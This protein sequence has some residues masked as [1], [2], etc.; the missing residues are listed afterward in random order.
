MGLPQKCQPS[1]QA[2]A[3]ESAS[4]RILSTTAERKLVTSVIQRKPTARS[5]IPSAE[6]SLNKE[7]HVGCHIIRERTAGR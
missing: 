3:V 7:N 2:R 4:V 6:R 5:I 1:I